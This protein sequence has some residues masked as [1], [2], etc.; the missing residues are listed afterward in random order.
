MSGKVYLVGAGPG[1]PE[2]L[3]VKALSVL[4][5][6]DAVLHDELVSKPILDLIPPRAVLLDVGK[7]GGETKRITQ[8]QINSQ[9]I[10]L[11]QSGLRVTRLKGGDPLIFGRAG[12]EMSALRQAHI[13]FEI[14]PGITAALGAAA[15]AQIPLTHRL[16]SRALILVSGHSAEGVEELDWSALVALKATLVVYM[17]CDYARLAHRLRRSGLGAQTA[18]AIISRATTPQEQI[19]TTT[20]GRLADA[21]ILPPP[22]LLIIGSAVELELHQSLPSVP[23]FWTAVT[24]GAVSLAIPADAEA[25]QPEVCQPNA[26]PPEA[27]PQSSE[28]LVG[29]GRR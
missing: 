6:T 26:R 21:S 9:L 1:D 27:R 22:A 24:G 20:L 19:L 15:T 25:R 5:N 29:G 23:D 2:L 10:A 18:C 11:A 16:A 3:T 28:K 13:D 8:E 17:P 14:V 7:R 4:Q 12:E